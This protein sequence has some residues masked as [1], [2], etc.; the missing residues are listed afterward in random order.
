MKINWIEMAKVGFAGWLLASI[1]Q[2]LGA[3]SWVVYA[4]AVGM[5]LFWIGPPVTKPVDK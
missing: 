1:L 2:V 3:E 4:C 5:G